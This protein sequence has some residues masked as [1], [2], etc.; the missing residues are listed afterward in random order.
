MVAIGSRKMRV[1]D[2]VAW[3][4]QFGSRMAGTIVYL[5]FTTLDIERVDGGRCTV[6][7]TRC[8]LATPDDIENAISE[9]IV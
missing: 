7:V 6:S 2:K 5:G 4:T 3:R 1:G 9:F 8:K